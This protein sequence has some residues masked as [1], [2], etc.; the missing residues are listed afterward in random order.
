MNRPLHVL[1]A[2]VV[3]AFYIVLLGLHRVLMGEWA[4]HVTSPQSP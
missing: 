4:E 3:L 1:K 2:I